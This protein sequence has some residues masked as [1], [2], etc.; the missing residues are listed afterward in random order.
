MTWRAISA[1]PYVAR[2]VIQRTLNP[3]LLSYREP[4]DVA[5]NKP[6]TLPAPGP[7]V[8]RLTPPA[9]SKPLRLG[10]DG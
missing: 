8:M 5:S 4:Y 10:T 1:K 7:P 2:Q 3:R 6:L 9:V